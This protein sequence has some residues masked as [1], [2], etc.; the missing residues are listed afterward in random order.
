MVYDGAK[1]HD[2]GA[3][4]VS[5]VD[6]HSNYLRLDREGMDP[7]RR[8]APHRARRSGRYRLSISESNPKTRPRCLVLPEADRQL[9]EG[10]GLG[11]P[12]LPIRQ[13]DRSGEAARHGTAAAGLTEDL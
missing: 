12:S 6:T 1:H 9:P 3:N 8:E 7:G 10:A 4:K 11:A 13:I 2:D 5:L